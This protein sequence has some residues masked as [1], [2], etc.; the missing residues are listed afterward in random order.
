MRVVR[1]RSVRRILPD[2]RVAESF[3]LKIARQ[4]VFIH[5][6]I[7]PNAGPSKNGYALPAALG[8]TA[9]RARP[10]SGEKAVTIAKLKNPVLKGA[11][12]PAR[13]PR[14]LR[15]TR[16]DDSEVRPARLP[17]PCNLQAR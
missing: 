1:I 15:E 11:H 3:L 2:I 14:G 13:R 12:L 6:M 4:F 9:K 8:D 5:S 17:S 7:V 16:A 10:S